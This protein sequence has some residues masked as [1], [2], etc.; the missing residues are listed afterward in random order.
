M[1]TIITST[2]FTTNFSL[3]TSP[4]KILVT[5]TTDYTTPAI[6]TTGVKGILKCTAP[7][8]TIFY[9]NTNYGAADIIRNVS[10][11][12]GTTIALPLNSDGTVV[13]GNYTVEMNT[14][15][16]DGTN[17]VY[18]IT[19]IHTYNFQYESPLVSINQVVDC[20]SPL[21][22]STDQTDYVVE[23]VTPTITRTHNL[24]YPSSI[25]TTPLTTSGAE[26]TT[27]TFYSGGTQTTTISSILEYT[28]SDDLIVTD[29]VTGS[30]EVQVDCTFICNIY[31]C[32]KTLYN[33]KENNRGVNDV[34]FKK[35]S[36]QFEEVMSLVELA[37]TAINCSKENDVNT[38]IAKIQTIA[39]CTTD[40]E[41]NDGAPTLAQGL[42]FGAVNVIV[43]SANAAIVVSSN[44]VAGVTTYTLTFSTALLAKINASYN[45]VVAAGTNVTVSSA[46]VGDVT[47]YTV[48]A[49]V[50]NPQ[51]RQ[52]FNCDIAYSVPS[53]PV[54]V[55]DMN[56]WL[57]TGTNMQPASVES[58]GYVSNP[59][60][61]NLNNSFRVFDFQITPNVTY[62]VQLSATV[63][64]GG[65]LGVPFTDAQ[66]TLIAESYSIKLTHQGTGEFFFS[67]QCNG[68]TMTNREVQLSTG[69]FT[70]GLRANIYI[71]Q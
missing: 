44:T 50:P 6:P 27:A 64:S 53:A 41:C 69:F 3:N 11:T 63:T 59:N 43:Q 1:P 25:T 51:N 21:F 39:N 20:V 37:F 54:V 23:G 48:N 40:C 60:W 5:D 65:F 4:K 22:T 42:G 28:F 15:I 36:D 70:T 52:E 66:L 33:N 24:Y 38:Y 67:F 16:T 31:C 68:V 46:T 29:T 35:Y 47:T 12:N 57:G 19:T 13:Q 58:V 62:K 71:S 8:G 56:N 49:T 26:I 34:L 10:A 14:Q 2:S 32:L 7:D 18:V 9:N 45:T 61:E 17:P 55:V 30:K